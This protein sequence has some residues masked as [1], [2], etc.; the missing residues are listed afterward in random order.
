[1]RD[2]GRSF[3]SMHTVAR[4][5]LSE[6]ADSL[7]DLLPALHPAPL[8][9]GVSV[10]S[11]HERLSYS[12]G[13]LVFCLSPAERV[14]ERELGDLRQEKRREL[15]DRLCPVQ[16]YTQT[17]TLLLPVPQCWHPCV[18]PGE[19]ADHKKDKRFLVA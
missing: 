6:L 4:R 13:R 11:G 9:K 2:A 1:V 17:E 3:A 10:R 12:G 14:D 19:Q 18:R 7:S 16:E 8:Y 15:E 5:P